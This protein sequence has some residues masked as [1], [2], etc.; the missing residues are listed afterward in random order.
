MKKGELRGACESM[1]TRTSRRTC[2][3]I[4]VARSLMVHSHAH[5]CINMCDGV[6]LG[7]TRIYMVVP[8]HF[9]HTACVSQAKPSFPVMR[10]SKK[11]KARSSVFFYHGSS[12]NLKKT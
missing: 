11:A 4:H 8:M 6:Y 10:T 1:H 3:Y 2:G 9:V 5:A 7:V 12:E